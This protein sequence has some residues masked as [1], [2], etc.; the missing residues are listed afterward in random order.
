MGRCQGGLRSKVIEIRTGVGRRL[1]WIV[2]EGDS[3]MLVGTVKL[4]RNDLRDVM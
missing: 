1:R 3:P 4:K 2:K